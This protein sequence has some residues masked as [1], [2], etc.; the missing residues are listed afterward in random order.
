MDQSFEELKASPWLSP[1]HREE[2]GTMQAAL[3]LYSYMSCIHQL[4]S[5]MSIEQT[6]LKTS[7]GGLTCFRLVTEITPSSL[8]ENGWKKEETCQ[9]SQ[10]RNDSGQIRSG[11]KDK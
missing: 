7:K 1:E 5:L 11:G 2:N 6:L 3:M 4:Y 10:V 9:D 8:V